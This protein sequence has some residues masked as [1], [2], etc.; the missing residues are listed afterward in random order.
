MAREEQQLIIPPDM[1]LKELEEIAISQALLHGGT[2]K[3]IAARLGIGIRTL[4][5]KINEYE[6]RDIARKLRQKRSRKKR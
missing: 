4:Q 2:R 6:L 5:I 1:T 3:E